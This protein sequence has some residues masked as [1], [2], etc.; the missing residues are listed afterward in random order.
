MAKTPRLI[1]VG[2]V[3]MGVLCMLQA[4]PA[5]RPRKAWRDTA[6]T[7]AEDRIARNGKLG[8]RGLR[9]GI[10]S[11]R[12][13]PAPPPPGSGHVLCRV[14]YR[15]L[16]GRWEN[17]GN[18]GCGGQFVGSCRHDPFPLEPKHHGPSPLLGVHRS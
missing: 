1:W 13:Q 14:R 3:T 16:A 18:A 7:A 2:V 17:T 4:A 10:W 15:R 6:R 12:D 9:D 11:R 5:A 8:G